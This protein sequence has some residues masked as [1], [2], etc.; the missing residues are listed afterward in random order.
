MVNRTIEVVASSLLALSITCAGDAGQAAEQKGANALDIIPENV[1]AAIAI[2][3]VSELAKRGDRFIDQTE[4]KVPMRLSEAYKA[5][6]A[7]LGIRNGLKEDGSAALMML[8]PDFKEDAFVLAVPVDDLKAMAANVGVPHDRL[9][10]GSVVDRQKF[11]DVRSQVFVRYVA[12]REDHL[13]LGGN[14][15]RVELAATGRT[16]GQSLSPDERETLGKNDVLLYASTEPVKDEWEKALTHLAN[17]V[18]DFP[19]EEAE[20]IRQVA[21]ASKE[22][23]Y[24]VAALRLDDGLGATLVLR[25][26]GDKSQG[27]LTGLRGGE[28]KASL[29]GLPAGHVLSAHASGGDGEKSAAVARALL[30]FLLEAFSIKMD[31][32]VSAGHHSNL[33]G[34]FGAGWQRLNGSRTALY[35]NENPERD[36]LFSLVAVLDT[37]GAEQFVKDMTGLARF[38]NASGLSPDDLGETID[39]KTIQRLIAELGD[40]EYRV[41]QMAS[42]KLGLVGKSAL[43]ALKQA[44]GS[45]DM[46]VRFRSRSVW[47]QINMSLAAERE[48]LLKR[49]LLSRIKP[50]FVY[51]PK[52]ETRSG[53]PIDV[54]RLHLQIDEAPV[55]ARLRTLLGPQW[56]KMRLATVDNRVIAL[57]G[58]DTSLIDKAIANAQS[59]ES[60]VGAG[61]RYATFHSRV[62]A[63]RTVEF[64]LSLARTQQ[65]VARDPDLV[66]PESAA[67]T[68]TSFGLS[69]APQS[70]RLDLFS[71]FEEVKAVLKKTGFQR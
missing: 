13:L 32:F 9:V 7:Y 37:D 15:K 3:N 49:D 56:S 36:G 1:F 44:M 48:D 33:V 47:Q 4:L 8:T 25:F 28:S 34:V 66:E 23:R 59:G 10:K 45:S 42:T 20:A 52:Q 64:H 62:Q 58:S 53:R 6:T 70:I 19:A 61:N 11:R 12:I 69:I 21:L 67:A 65:L 51:F 43:P 18:A 35:E 31:E 71:P 16:L 38:I 63:E 55:A 5:V 40:D 68:T 29:A 27:I 41:R 54:V 46:E 39:S 2:R 50:S 24:V 14:R 57:L 26:E 22:L 60:G 30:R 17:E